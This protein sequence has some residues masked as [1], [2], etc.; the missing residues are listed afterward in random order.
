M[1]DWGSQ[2]FS[3]SDELEGLFPGLPVTRPEMKMADSGL[4]RKHLLT[5]RAK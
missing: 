4:E 2:D 1:K 3:L 5:T